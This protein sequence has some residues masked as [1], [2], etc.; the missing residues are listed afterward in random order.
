MRFPLIRGA[1]DYAIMESG[2]FED[3]RDQAH[4]KDAALP[5]NHYKEEHEKEK[6]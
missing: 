5:A 4:L 2:C 3:E 6:K 1:K